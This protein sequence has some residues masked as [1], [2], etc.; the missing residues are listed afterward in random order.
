[1]KTFTM[2]VMMI[3]LLALS[4]CNGGDSNNNAPLS[5]STTSQSAAQMPQ[6]NISDD[7]LQPP[8]AP[9]L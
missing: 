3:A 2:I 9:S 7:T 8:K 5:Q 4:A 1:M 6:P